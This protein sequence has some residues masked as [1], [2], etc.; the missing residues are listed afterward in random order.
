MLF[1]RPPRV[2]DPGQKVLL[3]GVDGVWRGGFRAVSGPLSA[4]R[5]GIIV[6]VAEEGE[7]RSAGIEDRPVVSVPWPIED[8]R[9]E[10]G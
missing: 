1:R 6:R 7:Y 4:P 9:V 10:E 2:P 3:L 8:V 5:G